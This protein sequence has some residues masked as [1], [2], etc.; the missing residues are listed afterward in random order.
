MTHRIFFLPNAASMFTKFDFSLT[1]TQVTT[2]LK[3]FLDFVENHI[4]KMAQLDRIY[5]WIEPLS[6]L[7]RFLYVEL[8][9]FLQ[10]EI[11]GKQ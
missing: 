6:E 5:V 3:R 7:K 4:I 1:E 11:N 2:L 8:R 10:C 9:L